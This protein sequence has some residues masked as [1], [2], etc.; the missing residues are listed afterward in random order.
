MFGFLVRCASALC[1]RQTAAVLAVIRTSGLQT[2]VASLTSAL[3]SARGQS[4]SLPCRTPRNIEKLRRDETCNFG[5]LPA[6]CTSLQ[7]IRKSF[8]I[9]FKTLQRGEVQYH[10]R[11]HAK[12][13]IRFLTEQETLL[14]FSPDDAQ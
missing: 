10:Q 8:G 7:T 9:E 1:R 14:N 3:N 13:S 2:V 6:G 4:S 11:A 12:R 5:S